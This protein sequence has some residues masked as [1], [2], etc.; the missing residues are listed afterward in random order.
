MEQIKIEELIAEL[1]KGS[2]YKHID[3]EECGYHHYESV[4][5]VFSKEE[6]TIFKRRGYDGEEDMSSEWFDT[7]WQCP[8]PRK[9]VDNV[10]LEL[11]GKGHAKLTD[12]N[13][14]ETYSGRKAYGIPQESTTRSYK[15]DLEFTLKEKQK[16]II[17][18]ENPEEIQDA[19]S[20]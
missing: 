5:F 20:L 7:R 4:Q 2:D 3:N 9:L 10:L 17:K 15:T 16:P 18:L 1:E 8:L 14:T 6:V 19:G 11:V 13:V 12:V